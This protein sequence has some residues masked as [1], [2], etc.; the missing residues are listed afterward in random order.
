MLDRVVEAAGLQVA[1]PQLSNLLAVMAPGSQRNGSPCFS[2]LDVRAT[3]SPP[4][5]A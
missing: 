2:R 5:R 1:I 4:S 3:P